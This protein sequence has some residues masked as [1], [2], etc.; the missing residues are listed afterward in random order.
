MIYLAFTI[1]LMTTDGQL[2]KSFA[3]FVT[4]QNDK[5]DGNALL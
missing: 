4:D 1:I 5:I 3:S 2:T